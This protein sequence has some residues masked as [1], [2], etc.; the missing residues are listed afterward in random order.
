M[1]ITRSRKD[2]NDGQEVLCKTKGDDIRGR[3]IK[4]NPSRAVVEM[5]EDKGTKAKGSKWNV[6][7][8]MLAPLPEP[9]P[10]LVYDPLAPTV[11]QLILEA[12]YLTYRDYPDPN[13]ARTLA[14]RHNM[15]ALADIYSQRLEY[16]QRALGRGVT[17][18][19][20]FD[21]RTSYEQNC[22]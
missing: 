5:L 8:D 1:T 4:R 9:L 7:Y 3:I 21:W 13:D 12:I 20:S 10:P 11:T 18:E 16:L 14:E 17:K 2:Y 15:L 6:P 19:E 22:V